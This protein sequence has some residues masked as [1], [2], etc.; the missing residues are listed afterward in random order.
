M[1]EM[2]KNDPLLKTMVIIILGVLGFGFAFNIMFG[3]NTVGMGH[4]GGHQGGYGGNIFSYNLSYL[5]VILIKLLLIT[6]VVVALIA[7]IRFARH[8]VGNGSSM[9]WSG[10]D[11]KDPMVKG[12]AG[13]IVALLAI[14]LI[15]S[16]FSGMSG[17]RPMMGYGYANPMIG[18]L[19]FLLALFI[20]T[21]LLGVVM[22][23]Y[24]QQKP[25]ELC[26][27]CK[28]PLKEEWKCCPSCGSEKVTV[29]EVIKEET[30]ESNA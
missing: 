10:M 15:F 20:M 25:K 14:W 9:M 4:E 1:W 22:F 24:N 30:V 16:L 8:F 21:G 3:S 27:S 12:V 13:I 5:L 17:Y 26:P 6:L 19:K 7:L 23:L 11:L 18:F 29:V 2:V 28:A